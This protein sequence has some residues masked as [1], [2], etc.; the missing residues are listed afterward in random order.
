M[1][2][3]ALAASLVGLGAESVVSR[4][5]LGLFGAVGPGLGALA[6]LRL[7]AYNLVS[8]VLVLLA[9][10]A[11]ETAVRFTAVGPFW[12]G[13]DGVQAAGS[14]ASLVAEFE[15]LE[16][17][18][19]TSWPEA[20]FPV[21]APPKSAAHRVVALGGSSTAGAYQNTR[22][23]E[24]YPARMAEELGPEVEVINQGVGGWNTLHLAR[25][26]ETHLAGL[27]PDVVT[28][29]TGVNEMVEVP[30][31]YQELYA[32]WRGGQ[33]RA[34][35][36]VLDDLRLFHGLR[37]VLRA[38]RGS[39]VAVPP[40]HTQAHL[41]TVAQA[42]GTRARVL[43][44][45]E[46]QPRPEAL[47]PQAAMRGGGQT[48][49]RGLPAHRPELRLAQVRPSSTP[50][51]LRPGVPGASAPSAGAAGWA[52]SGRRGYPPGWSAERRCPALTSPASSRSCG[53]ADLV[54]VPIASSAAAVCD[55]DR[56][57]PPAEPGRILG[58]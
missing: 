20:G 3:S 43:L 34:G 12:R 15:A 53:G 46:S 4:L 18:E 1:S 52:G 44:L 7:R 23:E 16:A 19:A 9:F 55:R 38:L 35:P 50:T 56:H 32:A 6:L 17:R 8:L 22:L 37:F 39:T 26:A 31:P 29:Y 40:A 58:M 54:M 24:F 42:R 45:S 51:I 10:G 28:V 11:L 47:E 41:E 36:S 5:Y 49:P 48:R 33:L 14:T 2:L 27:Q 57:R 25:F 30:V 13:T 21:A